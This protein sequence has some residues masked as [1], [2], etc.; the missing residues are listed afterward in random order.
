MNFCRRIATHK[1][2]IQGIVLT[3]GLF[4][5]MP[6]AALAGASSSAAPPVASATTWV[7][8]PKACMAPAPV[9][10]A[11]KAYIDPVRGQFVASPVAP[12]DAEP[13]TTW[14][15]H[16][17]TATEAL[18]EAPAPGGGVQLNLDDRFFSSS[19]ATK[20]QDSNISISHTPLPW[21]K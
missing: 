5:G 8:A 7:A 15:D 12:Q 21:S 16:T 13:L 9:A 17:P 19:T 6:L 4:I 1:G 14:H 11:M 3:A 18:V 2:L 10:A 20:D